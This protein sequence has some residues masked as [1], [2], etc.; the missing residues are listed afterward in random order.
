M[1]ASIFFTERLPGISKLQSAASFD[2]ARGAVWSIL[3]QVPET[4]TIAAN[5][6]DPE[7]ASST[8]FP[9]SRVYAKLLTRLISECYQTF[10]GQTAEVEPDGA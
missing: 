8:G 4:L 9:K 5:Y 10:N 2:V 7:P 1:M 3:Q 6:D